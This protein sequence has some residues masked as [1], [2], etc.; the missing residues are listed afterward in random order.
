MAAE[1]DGLACLALSP[2]PTLHRILL[3]LNDEFKK[4]IFAD[5]PMTWRTEHVFLIPSSLKSSSM[6]RN[7]TTLLYLYTSLRNGCIIRLCQ[8]LLT[9]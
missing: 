4:L 9:H 1:Q 2:H 3:S 5:L 8:A 6:G 7:Q